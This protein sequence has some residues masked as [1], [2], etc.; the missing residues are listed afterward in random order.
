MA[1]RSWRLLQ[2]YDNDFRQSQE[3]RKRAKDEEKC[4]EKDR[5]DHQ[6][7]LEKMARQQQKQH[8]KNEE[9]RR[10]QDERERQALRTSATTCPTSV[11]TKRGL[12]ILRHTSGEF[13]FLHV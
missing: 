13:L 3:A 8:E 2:K 1:Q 4:L 12:R 11:S 6:A 10:K 7:A 9:K 5:R